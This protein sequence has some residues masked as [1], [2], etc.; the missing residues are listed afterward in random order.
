MSKNYMNPLNWDKETL[1]DVLPA[2]ALAAVGFAT[3]WFA[4]VIFC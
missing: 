3:A 2:T 1:R 4:I